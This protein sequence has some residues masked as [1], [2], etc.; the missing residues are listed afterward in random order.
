MLAIF[1][2]DLNAA[3]INNFTKQIITIEAINF[4]IIMRII[5]GLN[6]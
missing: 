2:I 5:K 4:T 1:V 6:N 3:N